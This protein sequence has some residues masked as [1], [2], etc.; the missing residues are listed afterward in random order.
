MPRDLAVKRQPEYGW[1]VFDR[2]TGAKVLPDAP[3]ACFATRGRA[4]HAKN[5][6]EWRMRAQAL[7]ANAEEQR[8][9]EWHSGG[10][11]RSDDFEAR[12][13]RLFDE[14]AEL[15]TQVAA[16]DVAALIRLHELATGA[17]AK[18]V[19]VRRPTGG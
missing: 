4:I 9:V 14:E 17:V 12:L 5:S 8:L 1:A 7:L 15:V 2:S 13:E 6:H 11:A 16:G 10:M 3:Y 19:T 18:S